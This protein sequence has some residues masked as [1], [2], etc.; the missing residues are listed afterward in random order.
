[1]LKQLVIGS[2]VIVATVAIQAE[3]FGLM[4]RRHEPVLTWTRHR[5]RRMAGTVFISIAMLMVLATMTIEVWLWA[6]VLI[7][8]GAVNGLE[9]AV[10]FSLVCFTTLGFGDITLPQEWRLLSALIGANG[11]LMFG[12]STAFMVELIR[13]S[14]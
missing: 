1:M 14:R 7:A 11:F 12:W 3:M 13:K 10:Y 6:A 2:M 4:T 8:T 5:F 9:P